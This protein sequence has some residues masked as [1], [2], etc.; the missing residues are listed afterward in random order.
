M[1]REITIAR[2]QA[3]IGDI[4]GAHA[5]LENLSRHAVDT[6]YL[7]YITEVQAAVDQPN[8]SPR[9]TSAGSL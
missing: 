5:I 9:R 1:E 7:R 8:Y 6:G 4:T 2:D 3:G